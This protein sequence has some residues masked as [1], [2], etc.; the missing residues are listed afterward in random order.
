MRAPTAGSLLK[1]IA[2]RRQQADAARV[3]DLNDAERAAVVEALE[4][5]SPRARI[6]VRL[7][8]DTVTAEIRARAEAEAARRARSNNVAAFS[9]KISLVPMPQLEQLRDQLRSAQ[10][11]GETA[12]AFGDGSIAAA[13]MS[14]PEI[15]VDRRPATDSA[16]AAGLDAALDEID[17]ICDSA[18]RPRRSIPR[19]TS[20]R[21]QMQRSPG[22]SATATRP[23]SENRPI[24]PATREPTPFLHGRAF[25]PN[26]ESDRP[27]SCPVGVSDYENWK[28]PKL[29]AWIIGDSDSEPEK[30]TEDACESEIEAA[31]RRGHRARETA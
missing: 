21:T 5:V 31:P 11:A 30:E 8:V 16:P 17:G 4:R 1:Q 25:G 2:A 15:K 20:K 6:D 28:N 14:R 10:S 22:E 18:P 9:Y 23:A 26:G 13:I 7:L 12:V 3:A 19:V 29:P 24:G 27:L